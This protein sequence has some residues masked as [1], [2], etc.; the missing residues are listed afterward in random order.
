M[1]DDAVEYDNAMMYSS[2]GVTIGATVVAEVV[3]PDENIDQQNDI[4]IELV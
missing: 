3:V 4:D 2:T 1:L